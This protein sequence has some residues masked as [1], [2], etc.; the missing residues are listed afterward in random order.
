MFLGYQ[1][2]RIKRSDDAPKV[3]P[4]PR[5]KRRRVRQK[6]PPVVV[7]P[8]TPAPLPPQIDANR[9]VTQSQTEAILQQLFEKHDQTVAHIEK[10]REKAREGTTA[11]FHRK[12]LNQVSSDNQ[13]LKTTKSLNSCYSFPC[14]LEM[15]KL[16]PLF[17]EWLEIRADF[18][19]LR[20]DARKLVDA[21]AK[22]LR[23]RNE[24]LKKYLST[25]KSSVSR[26]DECSKT[27]K[28]FI[29]WLIGEVGKSNEAILRAA[30]K[31]QSGSSG[32]SGQSSRQSGGGHGGGHHHR[33]QEGGSQRTQASGA[34]A[35]AA[36]PVSGGQQRK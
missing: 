14:L 4:L 23:Q 3:I 8:A 18:H 17:K 11:Y 9:L 7:R 34:S 12:V 15:L 27:L 13:Y 25:L 16:K 24:C 26:P 30:P 31:P 2:L 20:G 10:K 35:R 6:E 29:T 33:A 1:Q 21:D 5:T 28:K 36:L 22:K 19:F 32:S